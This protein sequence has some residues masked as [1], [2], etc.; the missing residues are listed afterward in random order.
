MNTYVWKSG[1]TTVDIQAETEDE[2]YDEL[3]RR[4]TDARVNLQIDVGYAN[5]FELEARY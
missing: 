1:N 2:A 5:N 4:I 3:V